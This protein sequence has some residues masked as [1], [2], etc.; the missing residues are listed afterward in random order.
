MT[1]YQIFAKNGEQYFKGSLELP[2]SIGTVGGVIGKNS[3]YKN[4]L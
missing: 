2:I 3:I 4:T 1:Y